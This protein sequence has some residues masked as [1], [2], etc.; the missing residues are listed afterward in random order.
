[1]SALF[2][3]LL[4][5]L[6]LAQPLSNGW[7]IVWEQFMTGQWTLLINLVAVDWRGSDIDSRAPDWP[8]MASANA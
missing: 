4:L 1:M 3:N 7:R 2:C 5:A 8:E 6:H